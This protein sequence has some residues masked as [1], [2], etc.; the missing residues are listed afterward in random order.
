MGNSDSKVNPDVSDEDEDEDYEA[1]DRS[2]G[3]LKSK[4]DRDGGG[5]GLSGEKRVNLKKIENNIYSANEEGT[6]VEEDD[7]AMEV[8]LEFIP[9]YGK[10]D[11]SNDALVRATL[12][13][14]SIDQIDTKDE[15]GNT[16][17]LLACQY[18]CE[19]LVRMMLNKGADPNSLNAHGVGCL[20]FACYRESASKAIAKSLLQHGAHPEIQET[21]Y[22]CTPL[23]YCAGNG[24]ISFCKLL[25]TH[26]AQPDTHDYYNYTCVDYAREAGMQECGNYLQELLVKNSGN[27]GGSGPG[28]SSQGRRDMEGNLWQ[29]Y[30][31]PQSGQSY[32]IHSNTGECLWESDFLTREARLSVS[33]STAAPKAEVDQS[34]ITKVCKARLVGLFSKV[35]PARL[36]EVDNLLQR[37]LGNE[38]TLMEELLS[39]HGLQ[40]DSDFLTFQKKLKDMKGLADDVP[41]NSTQKSMVRTSS[42]GS[43]DP[44]VAHALVQETSSK[45]ES[46]IES[47]KTEYD[48]KLSEKDMELSKFQSKFDALKQEK[49]A[50]E[51]DNA[52]I[53]G[54]MSNMKSSESNVVTQLQQDLKNA[55]Q[56]CDILDSEKSR[57]EQSVLSEQE[58]LRSLEGAMSSLTAGNADRMEAEKKAAE[59]RQKSQME[60][61]QKFAQDIADAIK[62]GK[63]ESERV[64]VEL[65]RVK[66]EHDSMVFETKQEHERVLASKQKDFIDMKG[67]LEEKLMN[68][69][70]EI[71][72]LKIEMKEA[73]ERADA[74]SSRAEAAEALQKIMQNEIVEAR[75][76]M[77]YNSQLHKDLAREQ[78]ARK[79]LHNEM[80]DLKGRIRVYVRIRPLSQSELD[81][82][83]EES[84]FKD[85]KLSVVVKSQDAK[86]IFDFDQVFGGSGENGNS[87]TDIFRD[88]KHLIMS[89]IDGYNVCIF[90]YGQTGSG[91]TFTMIGAADIGECLQENGEFDELAGI[92][93]RAVSELF[94]LL[95]ER[96]AQMTYIVEVSMFQLYRDSIDDLLANK[97]KKGK[98]ADEEKAVPLKITLAE[99]S[100]TGL[101]VVEGAEVMTAENPAEVMKIF[102]LGSSRRTTASTQMNAESSRS[103]LICSLVVKQTNRK[104]GVTGVGKLTLVDLAGSEV[105]LPLHHVSFTFHAPI[106]IHEHTHKYFRSQFSPFVCLSLP[107]FSYALILVLF[108]HIHV[109]LAC[110]QIWCNGR[111]VEGGTEH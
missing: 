25:I 23:H 69:A 13:N 91:K 106:I 35:D 24:D 49:T 110:R 90:A 16:L 17:L 36:T 66:R 63:D 98:G 87:Q 14:L 60:R 100:P 62:K 93:P 10:D 3:P 47:L 19:D 27:K 77:Q 65:Q 84:V 54:R 8:L 96:N 38:L 95:N 70:K 53:Q 7:D 46:Q 74:Q 99:H 29:T 58:K 12:S 48:R 5:G 85:G 45:Y 9:Y 6:I 79:R 97:K 31:D 83:S 101:V 92:T 50:L 105:C 56:R 68:M 15:E 41:A 61:E 32:L 104:T 71:S 11:P 28:N 30:F 2:E 111:N 44:A 86:K 4:P 42:V 39:K 80:E 107:A 75:S 78:L 67:E 88:T 59:D 21:T 40:N 102:S 64:K 37:Y 34:V 33:A 57:L 108:L 18:G 76:I 81:R 109:Y 1:D 94:R 20:H 52:M 82:K 43:M 89:V 103:H 22:G 26:G 55:L 73:A 51:S 72:S